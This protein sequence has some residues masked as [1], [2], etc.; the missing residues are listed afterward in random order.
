MVYRQ[1]NRDPIFENRFDAGRQLAEK[2]SA[3]KNEAT[4]VLAI[5][6]GG[7]PIGLQVALALGAELDVVISRKIPIPL[8]PEGGF[9]AVA[10]D[11]TTIL[12]HDLVR[13]LKLTPSQINYQVAG[14]RNEIQK[15]SIFY[16]GTRPLSVV[17]GKTVIIVDDGLA[18][19][20]TMMA[21]VESVRRRRPARII[22][23]VPVASEL[24]VRKVEKVADRIVTVETA[25]VPK[26]YVSYYYRF[27]NTVSDDEGLKCLKEWEMRR[28]K[29]RG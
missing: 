27:W 19:G 26:F 23:A 1:A 16:R 11:G 7:L 17:T 2:L 24:A 18:S 13:D 20:Y 14:V 9:G 15:R 6:N 21:A 12:N 25:L 22:V 29:T 3:Y 8:R 5:P 4:I 28:F 10:D